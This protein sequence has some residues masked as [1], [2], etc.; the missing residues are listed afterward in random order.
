MLQLASLLQQAC[1]DYQ[2][3]LDSILRP[4]MAELE[5]DI[6][7]GQAKL[8]RVFGANLF[9]ALVYDSIKWS[10]LLLRILAIR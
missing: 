8:H 9:I 6:D 2:Q 1:S 4:A 10:S 5:T 3:Y 7:S